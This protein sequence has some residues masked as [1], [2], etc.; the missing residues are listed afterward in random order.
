[1]ANR[2]NLNRRNFLQ[3]AAA[4]SFVIASANAGEIAFEKIEEVNE[5]QSRQKQRMTPATKNPDAGRYFSGG[6]LH[7]EW[8]QF[9]AKGY[10]KPVTGVIYRGNPRPVCGMPLG[11]LDTGCIDIE[12][13]GMLGYNTIFN[14]LVNPR[15][16]LNM[17]FL[18]LHVDG[19]TWVLISD[20]NA[21]APTPTDNQN[22]ITFPPTD[23]TPRYHLI[24]GLKDVQ[25]AE[26]IDY[27]GHYPILDAEFQTTAPIEVGMRAF[28]PFIPGDAVVSMLP[29]AVF[30]FSLRNPSN[31]RKSGALA[32]SFPGFMASAMGKKPVTRSVLNAQL[33]GV[34]IES[35]H[36]GNALE[37]GYV[38]AVIGDQKIRIGGALNN[39]DRKSVV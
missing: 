25:T 20:K 4:G 18:G 34:H 21:K 17:P 33:K 36:Q 2:N 14:H 35:S 11:G 29:G 32:F 24:D 13:N 39:E 30:E 38:L 7:S 31:Q 5:P 3:N 9:D 19:K 28:S 16:L 10:Q 37:M 8:T 27:W 15:L 1:M 22:I 26:W 23:Y 12:P 6:L